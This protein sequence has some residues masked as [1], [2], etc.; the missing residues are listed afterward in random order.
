MGFLRY[1]SY[2]KF[3]GPIAQAIMAYGTSRDLSAFVGRLMWILEDVVIMVAGRRVVDKVKIDRAKVRQ[4]LEIVVD[5]L[6]PLLTSKK[7]NGQ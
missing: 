5:G 7:W 6:E 1:F 2:L 4:G 3:I